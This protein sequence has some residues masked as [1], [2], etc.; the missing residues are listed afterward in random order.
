MKFQE[1]KDKFKGIS[2][3]INFYI[4]ATNFNFIDVDRDII[5]GFRHVTAS[6][7]CCSEVIDYESDLSYELEYMDE[8]DYI[9]LIEILNDLN[10]QN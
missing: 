8:N 10:S 4:D 9:E 2:G 3:S 6:C 5:S 1:I 7:G